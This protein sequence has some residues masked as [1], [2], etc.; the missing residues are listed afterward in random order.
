MNFFFEA[1]RWMLLYN[2]WYVR[3]FVQI[4][5]MSTNVLAILNKFRLLH[6]YY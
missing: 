3:W 5:N 2:F 1:E 6:K 4:A